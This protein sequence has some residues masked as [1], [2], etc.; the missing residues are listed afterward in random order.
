MGAEGAP[1]AAAHLEAWALSPPETPDE[2]R[3]L[4]GDAVGAPRL[5]RIFSQAVRRGG[6]G[7]MADFPD[8]AV[9][10]GS[11]RVAGAAS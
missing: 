9:Q 8:L 1:E 4:T 7:G 10:C 2:R 3:M 6:P 5:L 11:P